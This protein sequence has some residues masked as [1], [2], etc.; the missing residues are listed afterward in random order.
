MNIVR[1]T[2][3]DRKVLGP[4]LANAF[5][6]H[7]LYRWMIAEP[8]RRQ[9]MVS[10]IEDRVVAYGLRYGV[11]FTDDRKV[12]A[13]V[14]LPTDGPGVTVSRMLRT[15]L[16]QAPFRA[17]WGAFRKFLRF[18]SQMEAIHRRHMT[19]PHYL[20][21]SIG[22]DPPAHGLGIGSALLTAGT[23]LADEAGLACYTETLLERSM[24]WHTRFGYAVVEETNVP[25]V[26]PIWAMVREPR[27]RT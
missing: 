12:S 9:K 14:I 26:G 7:P 6:D 15:G 4:A 27:A 1:A 20:Q 3:A 23:D 8:R 10:W 16:W 13:S 19:G 5:P 22:V 25:G 17:G 18:S 2:E 24:E 21:L 11:V